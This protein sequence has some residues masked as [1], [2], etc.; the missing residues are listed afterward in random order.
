MVPFELK[1]AETPDT[2]RAAGAETPALLIGKLYEQHYRMIRA[3]CQ[4]L[5]KDPADAED[6]AQQTFLSAFGSMI[7]GTVPRSPA[8]WLATI[9]RRE[10]WTRS[11]QRRRRPLTLDETNAPV[12][13][14][15]NPL[16]DAIRN[17]D[18]AAL[19]NAI[20]SLPRQQRSAFLMREFSGLSYAEVAHA[21]GASESAIES[22]LFRARRQ[23]RDGLES[24]V[25]TVNVLATPILLLQHRLVRLL[26]ERR[27]AAAGAVAS[28]GIPV[29]AKLGAVAVGAIA[30]GSAG[31]GVGIGT[32][33][34]GHGRVVR[35]ASPPQVFAA[36]SG[37][38]VGTSSLA[39]LTGQPAG[40]ARSPFG[41]GWDFLAAGAGGATGA[42]SFTATS[43]GSG[44]APLGGGTETASAAGPDPQAAPGSASPSDTQ[45]ADAATADGA[46]SD[47]SGAAASTGEPHPTDPMPGD[48]NAPVDP[49]PVDPSPGSG[50]VDTLPA[51]A[52]PTDTPPTDTSSQ[53]T[54]L[55][56]PNG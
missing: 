5:L 46:P 27:T 13:A 24:A 41:T 48:G 53:D 33:A 36:G 10:C 11:A 14:A 20:N 8:P 55:P 17:A 49:S 44:T 23:V 50:P 56:D 37:S 34:F 32:A 31:M 51:P 3:L 2:P 29:A 16:E 21:L 9:A 38:L 19:W 4:L 7:D 39:L 30:V 52:P 1:L 22:L 35:L 25:S 40:G 6:A 28:T 12:S 42:L 47:P 15:D 43:D 54:L 18:L 26:H 45:P